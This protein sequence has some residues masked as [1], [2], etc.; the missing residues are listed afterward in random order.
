MDDCILWAG[1]KMPDGYGRQTYQGRRRLAH[2]IAFE[3][4]YGPIPDGMT[5]DHLCFTRACINPQHLRLL[6][7]HENQ[8]N[9]RSA[10]KT[11]C[12]NG[13]EYTPENTYIRRG[14]SQRDC[15]ACGRKRVRRYLARKGNAA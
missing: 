2:R 14:G 13:H 5:V 8:R 10:Y 4:A 12:V 6:T 11:H 9:Q 15:R 7:R 3:K 1:Y